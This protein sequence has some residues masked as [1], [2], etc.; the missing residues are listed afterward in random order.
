MRGNELLDKMELIDPLFIEAAETVPQRAGNRRLLWGSLAACLILL[1]GFCA[2]VQSGAFPSLQT[3]RVSSSAAPGGTFTSACVF[4]LDGNKAVAYGPIDGEDRKRYDLIPDKIAVGQTLNEATIITEADLGEFMG[5][6][7]GCIDPALNGCRVYHY[8][9]YPEK[10]AI[11]IVDTP[12]G[13]AFYCG[14]VLAFDAVVGG[15]SDELFSLYGLPDSLEE[16]EILSPGE[17]FLFEIT[18]PAQIAVIF[19]ILSGKTNIGLIAS[20]YRYAQ[21]WYDAYGNEDVSFSEENGFVFRDGTSGDGDSGQ[22]FAE[23][24]YEKAHALWGK[25]SCHLCFTTA[26]GFQLLIDYNPAVCSFNSQNSYYVLSE[27]ETEALNTILRIT[28]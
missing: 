1:I 2:V 18:D 24:T 13:Y 23:K 5:T 12:Q 15:S 16:L 9:K 8:A 21:A 22:V 20:D 25:G 17:R 4:W 28:D 3:G 6:V 19:E 7:T 10:D 14:S 27:A 26:K 11:C